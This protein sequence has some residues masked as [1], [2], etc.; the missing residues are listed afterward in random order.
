MHTTERFN[1]RNLRDPLI[2]ERNHSN[3]GAPSVSAAAEVQILRE[4]MMQKVFQV[5]EKI[6][7]TNVTSLLRSKSSQPYLGRG[8]RPIQFS[9]EK[10]MPKCQSVAIASAIAAMRWADSTAEGKMYRVAQ[11]ERFLTM[12]LTTLEAATDNDVFDYIGAKLGERAIGFGTGKEY[13]ATI[14]EIGHRL[15][16]PFV[17][18]EEQL[19]AVT[20]LK[21][22]LE[23]LYRL[24][25]QSHAEVIPNTAII[26]IVGTITNI[27]R[28][29]LVESK[30]HRKRVLIIIA[31]LA[32]SRVD[33]IIHLEDWRIHIVKNFKL[34]PTWWHMA[35]KRESTVECHTI[36]LNF[37]VFQ[38]SGETKGTSIT[39]V[40]RMPFPVHNKRA[41]DL[42]QQIADVLNVKGQIFQGLTTSSVMSYLQKGYQE[43]SN[44]SLKR[45][46]FRWLAQGAANLEINPILVAL[47]LKHSNNVENDIPRITT[48]Y[49][50]TSDRMDL[51]MALGVPF[52]HMFLVERLS[53]LLD[54]QAL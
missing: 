38:K 54:N 17:I 19:I 50:E 45:T 29:V 49:G 37:S 26:V 12:R 43:A 44:H 15:K 23:R 31:L 53:M 9:P 24:T 52:L 3:V 27:P 35:M 7:P 51:N 28:T 22:G 4:R 32:A 6:G 42:F 34:K 1:V 11:F 8:R 20:D 33:E 14:M 46:A 47:A 36:D 39:S 5:A 2:S 41:M 18:E 21:R 10:T 40:A 16:S 25:G 13:V 48:R 30:D